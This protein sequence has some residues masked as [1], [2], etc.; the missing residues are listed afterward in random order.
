MSATSIPPRPPGTPTRAASRGHGRV[1]LGVA[2]RA[3]WVKFRTGA[4]AT[5]Q[6]IED[7]TSANDLIFLERAAV[8][9]L[10]R[11]LAGSDGRKNFLSLISYGDNYYAAASWSGAK[12]GECV[13]RPC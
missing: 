4:Y 13:S 2:V 10:A 11:S 12:A 7:Q 9:D 8:T 1:L 6:G 3:E 5:P